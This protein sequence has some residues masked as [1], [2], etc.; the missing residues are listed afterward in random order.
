MRTRMFLQESHC[1]FGR[2]CTLNIRQQFTPNPQRQSLCL[3]SDLPVFA[4]RAS[5]L[6]LVFRLAPVIFNRL[7]AFA[8]NL[9]RHP[10]L[11][12]Q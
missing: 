7:L 6:W 3:Y 9:A 12:Q 11:R 8:D 10:K 4:Q 1:L 5:S 2:Y